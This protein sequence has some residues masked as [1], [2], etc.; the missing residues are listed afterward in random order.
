MILKE[1]QE[2]TKKEQKILKNFRLTS[3][4][5]KKL[6][7][8]AKENKVSQTKLVEYLIKEKVS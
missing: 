1:L 8:L 3:E 2:S 6:E 7:E 4:T 5:A